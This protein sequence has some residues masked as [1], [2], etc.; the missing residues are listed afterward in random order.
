MN[1][2]KKDQD[3]KGRVLKNVERVQSPQ[4]Q[5]TIK[6]IKAISDINYNLDIKSNVTP[7]SHVQRMSDSFMTFP[8]IILK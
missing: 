7:I 4:N 6:G 8:F 2:A 1:L 3:I 5:N